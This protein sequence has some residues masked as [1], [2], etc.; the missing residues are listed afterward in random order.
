MN[1][2]YA[3]MEPFERAAM[4]KLWAPRIFSAGLALLVVVTAIV[5][6][7]QFSRL[8]AGD[9]SGLM[10][11]LLYGAA[12]AFVLFVVIPS[13]IAARRDKQRTIVEHQIRMA[14][15]Q[16]PRWPGTVVNRDPHV[17]SDNAVAHAARTVVNQGMDPM[18]R[19]QV[20]LGIARHLQRHSA[21]HFPTQ[22]ITYQ[23]TLENGASLAVGDL[24]IGTGKREL[25]F[26]SDRVVRGHGQLLGALLRPSNVMDATAW[27]SYP[28]TPSEQWRALRTIENSIEIAFHNRS[29]TVSKGVI[30]LDPL[31]EPEHVPFSMI[32]RSWVAAVADDP[33][34]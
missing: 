21:D 1:G 22:P 10:A 9:T 8:A 34:Y 33:M 5:G 3:A 18:R 16:Q 19:R 11:W 28:M 7:V 17:D 2:V 23:F 25:S 26:S 32:E 24:Q 13:A 31:A 20:A 4:P 27:F 6:V 14:L 30:L 29:M 15:P 12:P